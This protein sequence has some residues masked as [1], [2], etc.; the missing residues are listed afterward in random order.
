L[1]EKDIFGYSEEIVEESLKTSEMTLIK[2]RIRGNALKNYEH[3]NHGFGSKSD[4][5]PLQSEK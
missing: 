1:G 3:P 4:R 5:K 2:E